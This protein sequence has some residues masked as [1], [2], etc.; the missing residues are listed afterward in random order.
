M[1]S[2]I[3]EIENLSKLYRLGTVGAGSLRESLEQFW[4]TRVRGRPLQDWNKRAKLKIPDGRAGPRPN[5][6]WALRETSLT[7]NEG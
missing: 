3:I 4:T 6:M 7:I 2:P 1:P 5:T